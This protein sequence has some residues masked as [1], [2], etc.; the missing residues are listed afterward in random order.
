MNDYRDNQDS[1]E[2]DVDPM[3]NVEGG[4]VE[5]IVEI[6]LK[7]RESMSDL[8]YKRVGKII[9][10]TLTQLTEIKNKDHETDILEVLSGLN[11]RFESIEKRI[12]ALEESLSKKEHNQENKRDLT[13]GFLDEYKKRTF[14]KY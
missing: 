3:T 6:F 13:K 12:S 8:S 4:S 1:F 14:K 9:S 2:D 7:H 5:N 11:K 10:N